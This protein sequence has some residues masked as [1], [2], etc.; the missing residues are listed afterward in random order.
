M[1]SKSCLRRYFWAN[2]NFD[3]D[4]SRLS[5]QIGNFAR[6]LSKGQVNWSCVQRP[7]KPKKEK[8][9]LIAFVLTSKERQDKRAYAKPANKK[10]NL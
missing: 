7:E 2:H 4:P 8:T 6:R 10:T 3:L 1:E 9:D 5:V